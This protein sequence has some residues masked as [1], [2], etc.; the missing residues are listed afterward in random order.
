MSSNETL[1]PGPNNLMG[2]H[3]ARNLENIARHGRLLL[4]LA[5]YSATID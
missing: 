2:A 4:N 3:T 5:H 1:R